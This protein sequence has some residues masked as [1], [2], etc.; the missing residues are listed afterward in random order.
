ME[1]KVVLRKEVRGKRVLPNEDDVVD[2]ELFQMGEDEDFLGLRPNRDVGEGQVPAARTGVDV[3]VEPVR[4]PQRNLVARRVRLNNG[5]VRG[6]V[7][8]RGMQGVRAKRGRSV[9][10]ES[11]DHLLDEEDNR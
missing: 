8:R 4:R 7:G 2:A 11:V 6:R 5:R 1:L 3:I 9:D 10:D